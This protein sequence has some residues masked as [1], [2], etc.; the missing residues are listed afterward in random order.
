M[1][2]GHAG[3]CGLAAVDGMPHLADDGRLERID[4]ALASTDEGDLEVATLARCHGGDAVDLVQ[5]AT[6]LLDFHRVEMKLRGGEVELLLD[7]H[8]LLCH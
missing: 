2:A 4:V 1:R 7:A 5:V 3:R 8:G 6:D